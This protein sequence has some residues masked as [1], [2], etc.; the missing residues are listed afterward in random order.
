MKNLT[1]ALGRA[2][3]GAFI[4]DQDQRVLYW[5]RS[6]EEILG[7]SSANAIGRSCHELLEGCDPCDQLICRKHCRI[8]AAALAGEVVSDYDLCVR[9]AAGGKR[10]IN[11]ST[12]T[13][14]RNDGEVCPLLIH[15]FRDATAK[16]QNE[17]FIK[18]VLHAATR[19]QSKELVALAPPS[20]DL[21]TELTHREHEVLSLLAEG[22]GTEQM[23]AAL[24]ISTSTVRNHV[25]NVLSKFQVHSR[26]EA[27]VYASQHGLLGAR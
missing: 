13:F 21:V 22:L 17:R 3:D 10:W 25:R 8:T 11:I 15:L 1:R 2:A 4:T 20:M 5:N 7:H 26:L 18:Q 16:V 9:T 12:L 6:A 24:S 19:L 14:P 27:V 23:A